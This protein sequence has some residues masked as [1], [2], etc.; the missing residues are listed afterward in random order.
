MSSPRSVL[1]TR[2]EP[3]A[4]ET[5]ALL[6][7]RGF[8]P[9]LAPMLRIA[10]LPARLP[11]PAR[12]QAVLITSGNA[13]AALPPGFHAM[14]LLAVG[15][16]T[17]RRAEAAGFTQV[18]SAS[19]D[20][21]ALARLA[22]ECLDPGGTALLLAAGRGQG[23]ALAA[24]LRQQGFEVIRRAVYAARPVRYLP[25]PAHAAIEAGGLYAALFYSAETAHAFVQA[26]PNRLYPALNT[27]AALVI[28]PAAAAVL[29]ALPW[30]DTRVAA[31]P[32][33][34]ALLALL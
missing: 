21:A 3:G 9:V 10:Q 11:D 34:A 23:N 31:H 17:A 13:L 32:D 14:P 20:A 4:H 26:L 1:I 2:P 5:A 30:R 25:A 12:L 18:R 28:G 6:R 15:D 8:E 24:A 7:A 19:G 16:A 27:V 22:A 29:A 33:Q